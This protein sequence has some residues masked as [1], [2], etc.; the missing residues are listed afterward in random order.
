[1]S[2]TSKHQVHSRPVGLNA[3]KLN[4]NLLLLDCGRGELL[5]FLPANTEQ[6][7]T[8]TGRSLP[9][10]ASRPISL[11]HD[12]LPLFSLFSPSPSLA[13]PALQQVAV[14]QMLK[15]ECVLGQIEFLACGSGTSRFL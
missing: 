4:L 11:A 8:V 6:R 10:A 3:G 14:Q 15:L 7:H 1:M 2:H 9:L 5:Q 13:A 12:T